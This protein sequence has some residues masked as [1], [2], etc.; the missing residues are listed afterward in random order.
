MLSDKISDEEMEELE[1]THKKLQEE[2]KKAEKREGEPDNDDD[3]YE[4]APEMAGR[5]WWETLEQVE[6]SDKQIE[7]EKKDKDRQ[8]GLKVLRYLQKEKNKLQERH[9]RRL[10]KHEAKKNKIMADGV[11]LNAGDKIQKRVAVVNGTGIEDYVVE[12]ITVSE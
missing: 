12:N 4:D 5:H 6:K 2:V 10:A 8:K 11:D 9:E 7:E 3:D 1:K